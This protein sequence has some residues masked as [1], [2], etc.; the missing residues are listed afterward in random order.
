MSRPFRTG[1]DPDQDQDRSGPDPDPTLRKSTPDLRRASRWLAAALIPLGP[2]AVA[3]LRYALPYFTADDSA[4]TVREAAAHEGRQS[5]VLWCGYAAV[6]TLVPA[7][8]WVGRLTRRR[9]PRLTAAALLLLVPGYLS[10]GWMAGADALLWSG[11]RADLPQDAF[12]R[13]YDAVHP[14]TDIAV[15]V[16]VLGHLVGT[17]LLGIALWRT[18]AV[19][20]W[21][22]VLVVGCQPLHL[23]SVV[24]GVPALDLFAWGLNA[25]GFAAAS[26]A[27]LR[28]PDEEWDVAPAA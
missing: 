11:A 9:A 28:T 14:T 26:A 17:V 22:A 6:L 15:I 3:V 24:A 25:A 4:A 12:V 2:A 16:F 10:L 13:L 27:V 8:L 20:R 1:L 5:L 19:P 7:V 18:R 21:A 23:A